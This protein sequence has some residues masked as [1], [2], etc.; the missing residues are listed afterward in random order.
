MVLSGYKRINILKIKSSIRRFSLFFKMRD[1]FDLDRILGRIAEYFLLLIQFGFGNHGTLFLLCLQSR[2]KS[3][4]Q[5]NPLYFLLMI[6]NRIVIDRTCSGTSD[7]P[8]H[9]HNFYNYS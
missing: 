3:T 2:T 1:R 8:I 5:D 9:V 7:D 4:K 6:Y